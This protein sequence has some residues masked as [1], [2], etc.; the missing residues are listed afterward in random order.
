MNYN[1]SMIKVEN[2]KILFKFSREQRLLEYVFED[3]LSFGEPIFREFIKLERLYA[4]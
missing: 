3:M 2:K 4:L 1:F